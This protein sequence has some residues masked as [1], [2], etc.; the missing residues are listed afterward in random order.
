MKL[1]I[2]GTAGR[3]E[4]LERLNPDMFGR[5]CE[6]TELLIRAL[7]SNGETVD[8]LVSGGAAWADHVAVFLFLRGEQSSIPGDLTLSLHTPSEW[9]S[10]KDRYVE[11]R[12]GHTANFHH[13]NFQLKT[14][15]P[16]LRQIRESMSSERAF[17]ASGGGFR[18]RNQKIAEEAD[19]LLAMTFGQGSAVKPK[20]GTE[21]TVR[22][23]AALGKTRLFHLDLNT[24]R[25]WENLS[26]DGRNEVPKQE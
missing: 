4:D 26:V 25:L 15:I 7:R 3:K 1:G 5:M 22:K 18:A 19:V 9:D 10:R 14:G 8:G 23:Y 24:M 13:D 21:D 16:S 6:Q 11:N 12:D 2:I 17:V 20:S